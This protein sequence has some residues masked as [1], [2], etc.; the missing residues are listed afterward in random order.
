MKQRVFYNKPPVSYNSIQICLPTAIQTTT[1]TTDDNSRQ[2]LFVKHKKLIQ[3]KKMNLIAILLPRAEQKYYQCQKAFDNELSTMWENHRNLVKGKGMLIPL[4]TL[5]EERLKNITDRWR[6]FYG[7]HMKYYLQTSYGDAE[8]AHKNGNEQT[9]KRIGFPSFLH[10][11]TNHTFSRKQIQLL[12]RGPTYVPPCQ[13]HLSSSCQSVDNR[14]RKQLAPLK[15]QLAC[16]FTKYRTN[17]NVIMNM[18]AKIH[19][20]F[21]A[22]FSSPLPPYVHQRALDEKKLVQSIRHS[23]KQNNLILRRTADNMNT[24]YLDNLTRFLKQNV[25]NI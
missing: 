10:I 2:S 12:N 3:Q 5:I 17:T 18:Q 1:T 8:Y 14:I 25:M 22:L 20:K 15:H 21:K 16:L 13:M 23:L 7:H 4:I 9:T 6:D 24:F 11:H 19:D